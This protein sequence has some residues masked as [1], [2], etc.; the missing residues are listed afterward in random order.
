MDGCRTFGAEQSK[1]ALSVR[2]K[3][4][5]LTVNPID[6]NEYLLRQDS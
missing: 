2:Q 4:S 1:D 3:N 5:W 6:I